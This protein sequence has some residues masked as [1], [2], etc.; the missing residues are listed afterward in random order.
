MFISLEEIVSKYAN[1]EA[2]SGAV[3][4]V[5]LT[6]GTCIAPTKAGDGVR[7]YRPGCAPRYAAFASAPSIDWTKQYPV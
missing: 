5:T 7:I 1:R 6:D 3:C 2:W 4:G